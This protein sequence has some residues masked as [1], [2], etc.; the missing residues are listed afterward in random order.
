M[1]LSALLSLTTLSRESAT[2]LQSLRD[3]VNI[4][5]SALKALPRTPA[6]LWNDLLVHLVVQK[7]DPV[8]KKAWSVKAS[9]TD[10]P[11]VF[12]KLDKFILN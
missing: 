12:D 5:V 7:L 2:E 4:A 11:P 9:E 3:K 1:H 8:T 10:D 6:E